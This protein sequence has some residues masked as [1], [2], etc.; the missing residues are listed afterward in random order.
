MR[1]LLS[2]GVIAA[3]GAASLMVIP[4]GIVGASGT[5]PSW[6]SLRQSAYQA[7]A[8]YQG[9]A[10]PLV[11]QGHPSSISD[12][13]ATTDSDGVISVEQETVVTSNAQ[14]GTEILGLNLLGG[15]QLVVDVYG[16]TSGSGGEILVL[17]P[18]SPEIAGSYPLYAGTS[19]SS[20]NTARH[21]G[22]RS[23]IRLVTI[24]GCSG[25]AYPP[26]VIGSTF[27]PLVQG[28]GTISCLT[29]ESLAALVSL[30]VGSTHV[31]TTAGGTDIGTYLSVNS[32]FGCHSGSATFH[33]A[34]LW[35]VNG[36]LQGGTTSSPSSLQCAS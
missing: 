13:S 36:S 7:V 12:S 20:A 26:G 34:E 17:Q 33:T 18:G 28:D 16:P 11:I 15:R 14:G 27:G 5:T 3:L 8:S 31:G 32:Y 2:A 10:S 21:R 25:F 23:Q 9:T 1:K 24:G 35:S 4:S 29:G 22:G 30:Y 6:S 19:A